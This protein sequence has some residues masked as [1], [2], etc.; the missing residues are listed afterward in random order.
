MTQTSSKAAETITAALHLAE[1]WLLKSGAQFTHPDPQLSGGFAGWY[2]Q[3]SGDYPYL[4]PE[5]TGYAVTWLMGRYRRTGDSKYLHSATAAAQWLI[6]STD[7]VTGG[8][9]ALI[10]LRT[11][12]FDN[13]QAS[14]Y[15]FDAGVILTGLTQ[16]SGVTQ[17]EK[18]LSTASRTA[19]WLTGPARAGLGFSARCSARDGQALPPDGS[20]WSLAPGSY[21]T[22][23]SMGLAALGS[24]I[25]ADAY[26]QAAIEA[27]EFALGF[28]TPSG[29]FA[30]F[31]HGGTNSH[32][33]LYSAEGL[34]A[35]GTACG[36]P[37]F[38]AAS[39]RATAWQFGSRDASGAVARHWY[40][41]AL[42]YH[43]RVDVVSQTLRMGVIH[44]AVGSGSETDREAYSPE[45]LFSLA[46]RLLSYQVR[47]DNPKADGG[48]AFGF[49]SNGEPTSDVNTWVTL[50]ALQALELY[51]DWLMDDWQLQPFELV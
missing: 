2:D 48:F 27:C 39:A 36:R 24:A 31:D 9:P 26:V 23:I 5:I 34:W 13:K 37:E 25:G 46:E 20:G 11:S 49:L 7:P 4:Y 1:N 15:T 6:Q 28:Q 17:D 8:F 50:F 41:G 44:Q 40:H 18:V 33:Q 30:T 32:P 3:K 19:D 51:R 38:I 21:H 42:N 29:R 16:L 35:V 45:Q 12:R 10:P 22:K 47:S 14:I 43:E